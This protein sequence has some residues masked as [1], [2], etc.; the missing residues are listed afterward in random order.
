MF[1]T[2]KGRVNKAALCTKNYGKVQEIT[3]ASFKFIKLRCAS[4]F[5]RNMI[6]TT[7][8][9]LKVA[10]VLKLFVYSTPLISQSF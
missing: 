9:G 3:I 5:L 7:L 8:Q 6:R 2:S 1:E 4:S 10:G